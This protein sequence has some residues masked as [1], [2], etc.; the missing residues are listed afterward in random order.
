MSTSLALHGQL[1]DL[2]TT[3]SK[4][5]A[6]KWISDNLGDT[7]QFRAEFPEAEP[8]AAPLLTRQ[9]ADTAFPTDGHVYRGHTI[10]TWV[11]AD[12]NSVQLTGHFRVG[13]Q[14]GTVHSATVP[15][16]YPSHVHAHAFALIAGKNY[17]DQ[18]LD[19]RTQKQSTIRLR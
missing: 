15:A 17:V 1:F 11:T 5:R 12:G 6:E 10:D 4:A 14:A 13:R 16:L 18:V 8:L 9:L 19:T 7:S 2:R 3:E